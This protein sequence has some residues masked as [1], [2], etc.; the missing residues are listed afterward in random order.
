MFGV[1][2]AIER[3]ASQ[4]DDRMRFMVISIWIGLGVTV[5]AFIMILAWIA[6]PRQTSGY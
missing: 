1:F 3:W 2:K 5:V 4:S 6:L